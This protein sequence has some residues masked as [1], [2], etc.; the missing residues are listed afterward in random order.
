M[1]SD[2]TLRDYVAHDVKPV[3]LRPPEAYIK[4]DENM[5]LTSTYKQDYNPYLICRVPPCLP[6]ETKYTS[7]EKMTTIPTYRGDYVPWNQPR[8]AMIKPVNS[9]HP[10]EAKFDYRTTVQDD[11]FYKGP[12]VT[13]SCKPLAKAHMTK[14]PLEDVTNYK[15]SYVPHP[16]EKRFVHEKAK[17][18]PSDVPFEG[19]TTQKISYKGL[20]GDPAKSMKPPYN[21]PNRDIPFSS[22]TEEPAVYVPPS[23]KMD[24]HTTTQTDYP[25]HKGQ[26]AKSCKPLAQI[27]RHTVPFDTCSTMKEAYKPWHSQRVKPIMPVSKLTLPVEPLDTLTTV[28]AHYVPH[29]PAHTKSCKPDWPAARTHI[30]LEAKTIYTTSYTPKEIITCLASYKEPPGYVFQEV[31]DAGHR[32]YSPILEA[33]RSLTTKSRESRGSLSGSAVNHTSRNQLA[34]TA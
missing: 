32:Q 29:P 20:P 18:K 21:L 33:H 3:K 13:Q 5:D 1:E 15:L 19:L 4:S 10:S 12:V 8:R 23:E 14:I 34:L 25:Y 16:V 7:D 17:Y 30:P 11:Y 24:L 22:S 2:E 28:R 9:Y 27:K 6:R 26:P 31:D